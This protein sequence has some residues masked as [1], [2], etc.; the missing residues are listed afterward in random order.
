MR[1]ANFLVLHEFELLETI[2]IMNFLKE[3]LIIDGENFNGFAGAAGKIKFNIPKNINFQSNFSLYYGS[4]VEYKSNPSENWKSIVTYNNNEKSLCLGF[5]TEFDDIA[6][7]SKGVLRKI[8]QSSG[9]LYYGY[10][11]HETIPF[12]QGYAVGV[13]CED[14][15]HDIIDFDSSELV[16]NWLKYTLHNE[17]IKKPRDIFKFNIFSDY[18]MKQYVLPNLESALVKRV[19]SISHANHM[20]HCLS[21]TDEDVIALRDKF[22]EHDLLM[23]YVG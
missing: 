1:K 3:L 23:A 12:G 14:E 10:G 16:S 4:G 20:I 21:L 15:N 13:Y 9:L 2:N 7:W 8:I 6:E 5:Q 11:Y 17:K 19:E 22:K 18:M